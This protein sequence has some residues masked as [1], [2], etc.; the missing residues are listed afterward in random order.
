MPRKP[1][2]ISWV[3]NKDLSMLFSRFSVLFPLNIG[4]GQVIL[5]LSQWSIKRPQEFSPAE[6]GL[7]L[8]IVLYQLF[9]HTALS[10][11]FFNKLE[12]MSLPYS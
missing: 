2:S 12:L 7:I 8:I 1:V 5:G 10:F 6:L 9:N 11:S 3:S 4:E